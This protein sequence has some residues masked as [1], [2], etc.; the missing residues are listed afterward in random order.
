MVSPSD[1]M[2]VGSFNPGKYGQ[3]GGVI[4]RFE[5]P[6]RFPRAV[7]QP[8]QYQITPLQQSLDELRRVRSPKLPIPIG[9]APA[10]GLSAA[11]YRCW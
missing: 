1:H 3:S 8:V 7:D 5:V 6:R 10:S 9:D 4:Q 2:P 11:R